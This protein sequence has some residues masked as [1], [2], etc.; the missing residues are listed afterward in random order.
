MRELSIDTLLEEI[1][2]KYIL[3]I[4]SG[5]RFREILAGEKLLVNEKNNSTIKNVLLEI[6]EGK[7]GVQ[8]AE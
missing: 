8:D 7:I 6:L 2:N 1:P 5:K 4:V 3:S